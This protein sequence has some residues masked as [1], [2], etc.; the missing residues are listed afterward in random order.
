MRGQSDRVHCKVE[1]CV[2]SYNSQSISNDG[3]M[4]QWW[5]NNTI[6]CRIHHTTHSPVHCN[7]DVIIQCNVG[8]NSQ[9][10]TLHWWYYTMQCRIQQWWYDNAMQCIHVYMSGYNSQFITLQSISAAQCS[11]LWCKMGAFAFR[12]LLWPCKCIVIARALWAVPSFK[13]QCKAI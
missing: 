12:K 13:L 10:I 6:Q 11:L 7:D 5:Y 9:F 2:I 4:M 1:A 8:Y 3:A